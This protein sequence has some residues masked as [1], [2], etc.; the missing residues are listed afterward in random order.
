LRIGIGGG[1]FTDIAI[2]FIVNAAEAGTPGNTAILGFIL[3]P[4]FISSLQNTL[5]IL[6]LTGQKKVL[7]QMET[8]IFLTAFPLILFTVFMSRAVISAV[9]LKPPI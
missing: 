4:L 6:S 1:P 2:T 5:S 9:L 8:P 3:R 7:L